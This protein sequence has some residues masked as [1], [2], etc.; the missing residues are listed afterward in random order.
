MLPFVWTNI[1]V[2]AKAARESGDIIS[3][4]KNHG[5]RSLGSYWRTQGN[6]S[7]FLSCRE[8]AD[9]AKAL[10]IE[11]VPRGILELAQGLLGYDRERPHDITDSR[12]SQRLRGYTGAAWE[13]MAGQTAEVHQ[14]VT[15]QMMINAYREALD[16]KKQQYGI[17]RIHPEL[18]AASATRARIQQN[19]GFLI[20]AQ[21]VTGF[22]P[23]LQSTM[24][25]FL[26]LLFVVVVP[27]SLLPGGLKTLGTWVKLIIWV[28]S[29]PLFFAMVN[30]VAQNIAASQ[31]AQYLAGGAGLSIA[32]QNGLA[33]AAWDAWCYAEGLMALVP[34]ISWAVLSGGGYALANLS[35]SVTRSIEGISSKLGSDIVDGN[36]SIDNQTLHGRSI[37]NA[38]MAQQQ[39]GASHDF[40]RRISDGQF[41]TTY[42]PQG[43]AIFNETQTNLGTHV[44]GTDNIAASLTESGTRSKQAALQHSASASQSFQQGLNEL[45]SYADHYSKSQALQ[46]RFGKS[47][48]AGEGQDWKNTLDTAHKF[49]QDNKISDDKAFE[50]LSFASADTG[51][52]KFIGINAGIKGQVSGRENDSTLIDKAKSSGIADQFSH[53]LN[54]AYKHST[55]T[56][57]SL[58]DQTQKQVVESIQG[59]FQK[60]EHYQDQSQA[61][62]AESENFS[63]AAAFVE[64]SGGSIT[65]NLDN[66]VLSYVAAKKEMSREQAA[67]WQSTHKDEYGAEAG[68][69]LA[70]RLQPLVDSLRSDHPMSDEQIRE[71]ANRFLGGVSNTVERSP[72]GEAKRMGEESGLGKPVQEETRQNLENLQEKTTQAVQKGENDLISK[73]SP[74]EQTYHRQEE[75]FNK[76]KNDGVLV[77]GVKKIMTEAKDMAKSLPLS[78]TPDVIPA[79]EAHHSPKAD[80]SSDQSGSSSMSRPITVENLS[81]EKSENHAPSWQKFDHPAALG[82]TQQE[83]RQASLLEERGTSI[84][85]AMSDLYVHNLDE[86][87]AQHQAKNKLSSQGRELRQLRETVENVKENSS[88]E[89]A[90]PI[91]H[92]TKVEK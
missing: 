22:L 47:H 37:A 71:K 18:I 85:Q 56:D 72:L 70:G 57:G 60:A 46:E 20:S 35:G 80:P 26:S 48:E 41:T 92:T 51:A 28:E 24:V 81:P 33:D 54:S 86:D 13:K 79:M 12:V 7:E 75:D 8:G 2:G 50:V 6:R 17:A 45:Y 58:S 82:R 15:Q 68:K 62:Y 84:P 78:V 61:S 88:P 77:G 64:S 65:T 30:G 19:S 76:R 10:L 1:L 40:S 11:E 23:S 39:L 42:T 69:F 74:L 21:A 25:A 27:L 9:R 29:W 73:K 14:V 36:V 32:T 87:I 67:R 59:N 83:E 52:L 91:I 4:I 31:G 16:D 5:H 55:G 49:A 66:E 38:Q 34:A 90:L 43:Q 44:V 53:S 63:R 89:D 3:L